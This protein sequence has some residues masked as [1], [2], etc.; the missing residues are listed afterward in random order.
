[1]ETMAAVQNRD[2]FPGA[3]ASGGET[4]T[5]NRPL[6]RARLPIPTS[7]GPHLGI[8]Q[9]DKGACL[10][11]RLVLLGDDFRAD[12]GFELGDFAFGEGTEF[13]WGNV[14][15]E[16][17]ELD[18]LDFFDQEADGLEHAANLTVAAFDESHFVPGID[19][20][21]EETDF[22]RRSFDAAAVVKSDGD[23]VAEALDSL[24]LGPAADFDVVGFGDV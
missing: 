22:S 4:L 12:E 9:N 5:I 10:E 6:T 14:K 17:A 11:D 23:A 1:M 7:C 13:A 2:Q 19:G 15:V 16:R 18:A 21:F 24:F 20:V 8:V 3:E